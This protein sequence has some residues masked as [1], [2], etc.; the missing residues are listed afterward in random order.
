MKKPV[1][2]PLQAVVE[3][4]EMFKD[5]QRNRLLFAQQQCTNKCNKRRHIK[6][7]QKSSQ[8]QMGNWIDDDIVVDTFDDDS[9][10]RGV[11]KN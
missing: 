7:R 2:G 6:S 1:P 9:L 10:S 3:A 5:N 8:T 11:S 4:W